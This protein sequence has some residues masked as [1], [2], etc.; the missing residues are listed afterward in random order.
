M[1]TLSGTPASDTSQDGWGIE[2]RTGYLP[3][4]VPVRAKLTL[5]VPLPGTESMQGVRQPAPV[6]TLAS[7]PGGSDST[8]TETGVGAGLKAAKSKL[9]I[10]SAAHADSAMP[11]AHRAIT[12][13]MMFSVKA[14]GARPSPPAQ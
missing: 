14:P 6:P 7:A 3:Q 11:Q 13:L 9:G 4:S 5:N 1:L 12:R 8:R 10:G 2:T